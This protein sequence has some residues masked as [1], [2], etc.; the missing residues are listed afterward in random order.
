MHN[1]F[2][3]QGLGRKLVEAQ[4]ELARKK[5]LDLVVLGARMPGFR[6]YLTKKYPDQLPVGNKLEKEAKAYLFSKKDDGKPVDPEIRFY[7]SYCGFRI[8]KLIADFGPDKASGN[9]GVLVFRNL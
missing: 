8:G 6:E 1:D 3:G 7:H 5:G 9:F 4:I 2:Q